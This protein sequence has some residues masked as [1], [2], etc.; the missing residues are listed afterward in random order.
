MRLA[1]FISGRRRIFAHDKNPRRPG[2]IVEEGV[3]ILPFADKKRPATASAHARQFAQPSPPPAKNKRFYHRCGKSQAK[4][5]RRV[6]SSQTILSRAKHRPNIGI[7]W[8]RKSP[9][10]GLNSITLRSATAGQ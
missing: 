5:N 10:I 9:G 1:F 4:K 7:P 2:F 3:K 6:K 8:C